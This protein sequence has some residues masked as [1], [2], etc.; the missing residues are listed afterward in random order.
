MFNHVQK[1]NPSTLPDAQ[2]M[3]YS[4]ISVCKPGKLIFISGQVAWRPDGSPVPESLSEQAAIAMGNVVRALEAVDAGVENITS[5]RMYI[6][7]PELS[8]FAAVVPS[9]RAYMGNTLP[10]FTALG[11][12]MLGGEGLKIEL[13]VTAVV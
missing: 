3:G 13:E 12:T 5:I 10:T 7:E 4:Q 11:V 9:L 1:I 8:D 6:V 2:A